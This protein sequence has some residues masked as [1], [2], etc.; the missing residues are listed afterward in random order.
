MAA[1]EFLVVDAMA[2]L[3]LPILL[4]AARLDVFVAN[5]CGLDRQLEGERKFRAVVALQLADGKRQIAA[6]F[7]EEM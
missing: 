7:S 1:P 6:E 2:P 5:A 3:D 4:W